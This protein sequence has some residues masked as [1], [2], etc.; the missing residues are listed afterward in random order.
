MSNSNP[1]SPKDLYCEFHGTG[2]PLLCLHGFGASLYSW[3]NFVGPLS[4]QY[5]LIL[6]DLK[7]CGKSPK[8]NDS[9]YSTHDHAG[10]IYGFI[11][12][13]NL[14]NLTLIGNSFGGALSLLVA[15]MLTEK[16]PGRLRSLI[17]IDAGAYKEYIPGYLKILSVPVINALAIYLTPARYAA[18]NVLRSSYY[19]PNKITEEQISSYAAPIAAPGG[20]HALL[21]TGKQIIPPN[22]DELVAKYKN[23]TV[24]TLIIWGKQDKIIS[25]KVGELLDQAIPNSTLKWIDQCGH[26][27]QEEKP[28]AT[29]PLVL[30]FLASH[31]PRTQ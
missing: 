2:D 16:D 28:E 3:R 13:H 21:E 24:P 8:P 18:K 6:L 27:P 23:I 30:D 17:L 7:G 15:I 12:E 26:V 5:Q 25:P 19:D 1:T 10:L 4:R 9:D 11:Q 31:S 14:Q 29:V 22:F 20:K